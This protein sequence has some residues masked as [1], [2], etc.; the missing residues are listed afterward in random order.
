[1]RHRALAL[2]VAVFV[3]L[4]IPAAAASRSEGVAVSWNLVALGDSD[5]TGSGD[6]SGTGWVGRYAGLLRHRIGA[7]VIVNNTAVDG[8]TSSALLSRLGSDKTLRSAIKNAQLVLLGI[9]GADLNAGDARHEAGKCTGKACYAGDLRAF[10]RNFRS[11]AA[12]VRSLRRSKPTVIRAI[13]IPN[14][15]PGAQDVVPSYVT[16]QIGAYQAR[17]LRATICSTMIAVHGKCIDVLRAFNGPSGTEN[18]YKKGLM[19]HAQ[20]CYPSG[21]GQQLIAELLYGSGLAPLR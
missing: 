4:T 3:V 2:V 19:N 9:G 12:T 5:A 17:T 10:G 1:M 7:K 6:P 20:C 15:I 18:A 13:T 16:V 8:T 21:K 14:A 11:I